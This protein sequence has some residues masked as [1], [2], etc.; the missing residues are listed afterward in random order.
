MSDESEVERFPNLL[1]CMIIRQVAAFKSYYGAF[2]CVT[3]S[4]DSRFVLVCTQQ[5]TRSHF[6]DALDRG[7][8]RPCKY[9]RSVCEE[10]PCCT[11]QRAPIVDYTRQ[12]RSLPRGREWAY[13]AQLVQIRVRG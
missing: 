4:A 2:L 9:I 10:V 11:G 6:L 12:L 13:S 7:R 5:K 3:W 8:G 1:V